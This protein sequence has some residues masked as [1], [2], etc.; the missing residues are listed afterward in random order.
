[1][2]EAE[3]AVRALRSNL[4]AASITLL[5]SHA[6]KQISSLVGGLD[7]VMV[8]RPLSVTWIRALRSL[9]LD[10]ALFF[11]PPGRSPYALGYACYLAGVPVRIGQSAEFGGGVLS[12]WH[13]LPL[14][15]LQ[16]HAAYLHMLRETGFEAADRRPAFPMAVEQKAWQLACEMGVDPAAQWT[17]TVTSRCSAE[18]QGRG[19]RCYLSSAGPG[20]LVAEILP[21]EELAPA[22]DPVPGYK[23][24]RVPIGHAVALVRC[25][26]RVMTDDPTFERIA[27]ALGRPVLY[28]LTLPVP[29]PAS[30]LRQQELV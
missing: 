2:V 28:R 17:F 20:Q 10:A 15:G 29:A 9:Q 7:R 1:M 8:Q 13:K 24:R 25:A 21:A 23:R 19:V 3:P 16:H 14:Q 26:G 11:T 27:R 18:G 12:Q 22:P 30:I 6:G 5:T 4:P